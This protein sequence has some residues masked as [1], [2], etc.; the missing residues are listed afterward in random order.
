MIPS[1]A[2]PQEPLEGQTLEPYEYAPHKLMPWLFG[3]VKNKLH[4][5]DPDMDALGTEEHHVVE[6]YW[7]PGSAW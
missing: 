3:D 4:I 5:R 1:S 6:A 7:G 2:G